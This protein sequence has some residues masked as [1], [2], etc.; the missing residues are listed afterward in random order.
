M[1]KD[2][3][4]ETNKIEAFYIGRTTY[5][6][7]WGAMQAYISVFDFSRFSRSV[8]RGN[9]HSVHTCVTKRKH[10]RYVPKCH[11]PPSLFLGEISTG[12]DATGAGGEINIAALWG[13]SSA[14]TLTGALYIHLFMH[15]KSLYPQARVQ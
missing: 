8:D 5:Y 10:S 2:F 1:V 13:C 15:A 6:I 12:T 4:Y 7:S 3:S 14:M 9:T 11:P